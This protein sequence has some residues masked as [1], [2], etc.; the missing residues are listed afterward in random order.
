MTRELFKWDWRSQALPD[1][2]TP[3]LAVIADDKDDPRQTEAWKL[4]QERL[5][6]RHRYWSPIAEPT[7]RYG[8]V[9][10]REI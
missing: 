4:V 6:I 1:M 5:A 7:D 2:S 8:R 10:R 9:T 3:Q